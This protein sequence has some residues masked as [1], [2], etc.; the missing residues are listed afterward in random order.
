MASDP[1]YEKQHGAVL[2][3]IARVA[4]GRRPVKRRHVKRRHVIDMLAF[5]TQKLSARSK[6]GY[7][8]AGAHERLRE[9][10]CGIDQMLAVVQHQKQLP[11]A[12]RLRDRAG[13]NL[14]AAQL[15]TEVGR[16]G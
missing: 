1:G 9:L 12:D 7:S 10:R 5:D 13:G 8:R 6:D 14:I 3:S 2:E 4:I 16:E 11:L 15:L